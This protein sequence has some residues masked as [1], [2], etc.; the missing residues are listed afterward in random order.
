MLNA[1]AS[2]YDKRTN[3][4]IAM[5]GYDEWDETFRFQNYDYDYFNKLDELDNIEYEK[6]LQDEEYSDNQKER[7]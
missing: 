2:L 7:I 1:L 5:W 6:E 3:D 4:Y